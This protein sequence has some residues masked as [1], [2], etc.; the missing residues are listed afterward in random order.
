LSLGTVIIVSPRKE[1]VS[2]PGALIFVPAARGHLSIMWLWE[3]IFTYKSHR[4]V[5]T[6]ERVLK[7]L[8]PPRYSKRQQ[9]QEHSLSVKEDH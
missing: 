3:E 8:P 6:G 5:T 1:L 7:Q 9:T 2:L 4:T